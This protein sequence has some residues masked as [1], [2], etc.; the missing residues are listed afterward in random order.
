MAF[1]RRQSTFRNRYE[2]SQ[3]PTYFPLNAP[4]WLE[5]DHDLWIT[6]APNVADSR[7]ITVQDIRMVV[8]CSGNTGRSGMIPVDYGVIWSHWLPA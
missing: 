8:N 3:G 7:W 4:H 5:G 6:D 1:H 2:V